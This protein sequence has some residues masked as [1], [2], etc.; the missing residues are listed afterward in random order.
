MKHAAIALLLFVLFP[1]ACAEE[2]KTDL[3]LEMGAQRVVKEIE[4]LVKQGK[5][6]QANA[7]LAELEQKYGHTKT[8]EESK[9]RLINKGLSTASPEIA[10]TSKGLIELENTVLSFR[11]QTGVWPEP[12][13]TD[14]RPVRTTR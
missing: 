1:A 6:E 12:A 8:Y 3:A 4:L 11:K 7:Q 13:A 14:R 10:L 5:T 9:P 2:K